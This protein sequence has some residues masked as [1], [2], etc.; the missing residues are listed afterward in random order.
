[1]CSLR[2]LR[3]VPAVF[4]TLLH[5]TVT[6]VTF[7][8]SPLALTMPRRYAAARLGPAFTEPAPW[9]L[10][11]VFA[12]TSAKAP[13]IFVLS[14]G[15]ARM[16]GANALARVVPCVAGWAPSGPVLC[17]MRMGQGLCSLHEL[18]IVV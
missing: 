9:T 1:L 17:S 3:R 16:L 8:T 15:A 4:S 12:D 13:I 6:P 5:Q 14:A 2:E 10:D 18:P 7:P 11:D